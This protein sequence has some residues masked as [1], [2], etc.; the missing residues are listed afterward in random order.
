MSTPKTRIQRLNEIVEILK[1]NGGKA[2]FGK[3]YGE[4]ALKYGTR[5]NTFWEYLEALKMAGKI[6]YPEIFPSHQESEIEI[7][8]IEA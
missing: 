3:L 2:T 7:K 6:D 4:M 8:L 1:R 5:K